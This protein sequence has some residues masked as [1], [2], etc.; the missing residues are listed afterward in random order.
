MAKI[1]RKAFTRKKIIIGV[2]VFT[3]ITLVAVGVSLVALSQPV[4]FDNESSLNVG[5][6]SS[7]GSTF[8]DGNTRIYVTGDAT[9]SQVPIYRFEPEK[10]DNE[11]RVKCVD[12]AEVLSLT[13]EAVLEHSER[14]NFIS[15]LTKCKS[16]DDVNR[17][18]TAVN[19]GYIELPESFTFTET[20]LNVY[21][22]GDDVAL[23]EYFHVLKKETVSLGERLTFAYDVAFKWGSFFN[24]KNPSRYYDEDNLELPTGDA[25]SP[26]GQDTVSGVLKDLKN[27]LNG[28]QLDLWLTAK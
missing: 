6:V 25:N 27:L 21:N 24:H 4:Y 3:A 14:L 7:S 20:E 2:S 19:K 16:P 10:D 1:T 22:A 15:A 17:L 8:M 26:V 23:S 12:Q 18:Q 28:I 11:G 5:T 13:V 9:K